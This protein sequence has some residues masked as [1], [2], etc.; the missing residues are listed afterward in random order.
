MK[1]QTNKFTVH[2]S[3]GYYVASFRSYQDALS[4][5]MMVAQ[6]PDWSIKE[7]E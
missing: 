5:K 3:L 7:N 4:Y 2:D 1:K 6:R